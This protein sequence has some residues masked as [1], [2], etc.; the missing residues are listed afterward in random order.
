[1]RPGANALYVDRGISDIKRLEREF[2]HLRE[3]F[4]TVGDPIVVDAPYDGQPFRKFL[5]YPCYGL[6]EEGLVQLANRGG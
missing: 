6:R 4:N 3:S 1:M 5:V 2:R